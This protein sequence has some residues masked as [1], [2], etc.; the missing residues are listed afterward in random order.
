ENLRLFVEENSLTLYVSAEE[1]VSLE[2]F[3]FSVFRDNNIESK[4]LIVRFGILE[5]SNNIVQPGWCFFLWED[6]SAT[7]PDV[8]SPSTTFDSFVGPGD[9][10]WFDSENQRLDI[11]IFRN[12]QS[13]NQFCPASLNECPIAY[14]SIEDNIGGELEDIPQTIAILPPTPIAEDL[15]LFTQQGTQG[16]IREIII[17]KTQNN[18]EIAISGHANGRLCLWE[19]GN[20]SA[21]SPINC[22]M[23]FHEGAISALEWR[24]AEDTYQ[25]ITGGEDGWVRLWRL[26]IDSDPAHPTMTNILEMNA[27]PGTTVRDIRWHP[28]ESRFATTGGDDKLKIWTISAGQIEPTPRAF[29]INNPQAVAWRGDGRNIASVELTGVTRVIDATGTTEAIVFDFYTLPAIDTDWNQNLG[30]IVT[31]AE[32]NVVRLYDLVPG[33]TCNSRCPSV[34]L[35]QNLPSPSSVRFSPDGQFVAISMRNRVDVMEAQAPYRL[36]SRHIANNELDMALTSLAWRAD[37]SSLIASDEQGRVYEW[38]VPNETQQ[39]LQAGNRWVATQSRRANAFDWDVAGEL[40][41]IVDGNRRLSIWQIEEQI[42]IGDGQAHTSFPLAV[43][44]QGSQGRLATGGCGPLVIIWRAQEFSPISTL[45]VPFDEDNC[46]SSIAFH[47]NGDKLATADITGVVRVWDWERGVELVEPRTLDGLRINGLEWNVS[48]SHLAVTTELGQ[49]FVFALTG[50]MLSDTLVRQPEPGSEMTSLDW[51]PSGEFVATGS[52]NNWIAIWRLDASQTGESFS[53]AYKFEGHGASVTG[54]S[55][56]DFNDWIASVS[57][58]GD[59]IV[60]DA[61]TGQRLAQTSL[62]GSPVSVHWSPNGS[63]LG[64]VDS[65][66]FFQIWNFTP[67]PS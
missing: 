56:N 22:E 14:Q 6:D 1:E 63:Q 41:A 4:S 8:C 11:A 32:D 36:V 25:F 58:D 55:W 28:F 57:E 31:L 29:N 24:T 39:R 5:L 40:I 60:W 46:G 26:D 17:G 44:W 49:L 34:T 18:R 43:D 27:H 62:P 45:S 35:A 20:S 13:I 65:E 61:F 66:G 19:I 42:R 2:G 9:K 38:R 52:A 67:T 64:V 10:F 23:S 47:P 16:E 53:G 7:P 59:L 30:N 12:R 50:N 37:G 15:P 21:A 3:Q 48:G 54:L 51:S 33:E